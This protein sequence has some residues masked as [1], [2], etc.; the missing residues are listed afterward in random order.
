MKKIVLL[1]IHLYQ[2]AVSPFLGQCCRFAPTCSEYAK[3]AVEKHGLLKGLW[4][5]VKRLAKCH[6]L[7][8]GGIDHVP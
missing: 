1:L 6:P 5:T 2:L 3:E 8:S 7:H 4:L